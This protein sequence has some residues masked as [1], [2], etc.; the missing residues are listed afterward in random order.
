MRFKLE[1]PRHQTIAIQS[2]VD[3][4]EGMECNT[5]DN[6][7]CEDIYANTC[8]LRLEE[9]AANIH[10]IAEQNGISPEDANFELLNI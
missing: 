2:V 5:F 4:F 7:H 1:T 9:M 10:F 8:S 3:I 6:A